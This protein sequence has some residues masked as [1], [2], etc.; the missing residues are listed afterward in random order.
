MMPRFC[1][2]D[3]LKSA[4]DYRNVLQGVNTLRVR[5]VYIDLFLHPRLEGHRLGLIVS[6]RCYPRAVDRNR[7]KRLLREYA[8]LHLRSYPA[9]DMVVRVK[10]PLESLTLSALTPYLDKLLSK[11]FP[12]H[13]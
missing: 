10:R 6:K 12:L 2:L 3:S 8:R 4:S 9:V 13:L 7:T 11:A 5:S 1:G